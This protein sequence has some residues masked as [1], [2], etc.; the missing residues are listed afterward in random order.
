MV[1]LNN[2][3]EFVGDL[4]LMSE[5]VKTTVFN[6]GW[7]KKE[8]KAMVNESKSNGVFLSLEGGYYDSKGVPDKVFAFTKGLFG[9][10]GNKL[11]I[12]W[13][14][15]TNPLILNQVANFSKIVID[16]TTDT[17]V[18]KKYYE[19]SGDIYKIESNKDATDE[20]KLK[21]ES[22]YK[23]LKESAPHRYEFL[24]ELDVISFIEK[25]AEKLN[26]K[27]F[28]VRGDVTVSHWNGKFYTNYVPKTFELVSEDTL[29]NLTLD[30]DL[31]FAKD[32]IDDTR[33]KKDKLITYNTY[34]LGYDSGHKKD[35]FFPLK[36][37]LNAKDYDLENNPKH[38]A[39]I[40]VLEKFFTVKGKKVFQLPY[41]AKVVNGSPVGEFTEA[42]LTQDQKEL[43]DIGMATLDDF[44]PKGQVFGDKVSEIRL[45]FPKIKNL[46]EGA[47][48]TNGAIETN[49]ESTELIYKAVDRGT[50]TQ[51]VKPNDQTEI[52]SNPFDISEDD[53]PF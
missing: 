27:K 26:G 14:D 28:K 30:L 13:E 5:P 4:K 8:L 43:I 24:H 9:G 41:S 12:P 29:N 33:F 1:K 6:S 17:E 11:E 50:T 18:K 46:G 19:L 20:E 32:V 40:N 7:T 48:F 31:Y 35:V 16:L 3:F 38:Q 21:L 23:E 49:F 15:R 22:L 34:I 25:Y 53:L 44:K 36:T 45:L 47:N 2:S 42:S 39:H 10:K 37:V 52:N 51:D